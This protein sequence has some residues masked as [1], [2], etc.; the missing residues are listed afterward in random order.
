MPSNSV[1]KCVLWFLAATASTSTALAA[2]PENCLSCHRYLGLSRIDD[3]LQTVHLYHVD[4]NYYDRALGPHARVRCTGCHP[5]DQVEVIPHKPVSPVSCAEICH[6]VTPGN[7]EM[8]FSHDHVAEML[9]SSVHTSEVLDECNKLLE[10]PLAEG[11]SRCLLC[12][13]EPTFRHKDE[14]WAAT[15]TPVSRC[16]VCHETRS[17]AEVRFSYWHVHAR[18]RQART[19]ENLTRLCG[20]CHS[21]DAIREA[22]EMTDSTATYLAS[23]HGKAMQLGSEETAGCLDCHVKA[24]ENVHVMHAAA[25]PNSSAH[26][27]QLPYT[28]RSAVC[29]PS[30]GA[31]LSKAAI[32]LD[33]STDRGMAF[34]IAALFLLLIIMTFGPSVVLQMLEFLQIVVGR[35]NPRYHD[36]YQ[37]AKRLLANPRGRTMLKRFTPHQRIQHWILF[38][39]FTTLAITG[40]P[41]K[42]ADRAWAAWL[43]D[44][45]GGL[46]LTRIIHRWAGA[47]LLAGFAYHMLYLLWHL[48]HSRQRTGK[49]WVRTLIRA[50]MMFTLEDLRQMKRLLAYLLFLRRERPR[51]DRF[52]L[53]E[54]FE[55]LGVFWGT[56]LLGVTG[57]LMW[58]NTW[59]T[60]YLPGEVM[61]AASLIHTFEAFLALLHVGI[62][63]T[64]G[65]IWM[66]SVFPFSPAMVTGNTT[67]EELAETHAGLLDRVE[68]EL[69]SRSGEEVGH[70]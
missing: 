44:T 68:E 4:P 30:A 5:R 38:I 11:Q 60:T 59:T 32:H 35:H 7:I 54:K 43:I 16:A 46:P 67:P 62:I 29:H 47:L 63:H 33:L 42:F 55:Y 53:E 20:Y 65:V 28:C 31:E 66:P 39:T 45:L 64:I 15:E 37:K 69:A 17:L 26:P 9:E 19:H 10:W 40:F 50:R 58:A 70:A 57:V 6:I 24:V 21:N 23:F 34:F 48:R 41:I 27:D 56:I 51:A 2:D 8:A 1:T 61:T 12:H 3:D 52:S 49:D 18:S 36:D 25:D 22:Y 14:P 13:E